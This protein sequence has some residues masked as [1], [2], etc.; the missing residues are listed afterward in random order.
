MPPLQIDG[1][2]GEG[3]GQVLRTALALSMITGQAVEITQVRAGRK[4]PGLAPQHLAGILAAQQITQAEVRGA[5]VGSMTVSFSP[6]QPAQPDEYHFDISKLS[7]RGSAGSVTLLFQ[8]ILLPLALAGG[9]SRVTVNGGTHVSM[10][11]PAYYFEKV[12]LPAL[13]GIGIEARCE[14]ESPGWYPQGGGQLVVSIEGSAKLKGI[15]LS[16]RGEFV[17][18]E[19]LAVASNLP[20]DI[21]QRIASRANNVCKEAGL[22]PGIQARRSSGVSTGVGIVMTIQYANVVAGFSALG[23]R[24]KP[25][26]LVADEAALPLVA[27]HR[28]EMALEPHLPDQILPALALADGPSVLTTQEITLHTLT[29]IAVVRHFIDRE[30]SVEGTEKSPGTI[31][32]S[33]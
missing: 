33:G 10:S 12:L 31:R 23:E 3:G 32:V 25:S 6:S 30:I 14:M 17:R 11:P 7:G 20:S 16:S 13:H 27:F 18:V 21:P 19:G 9:Q 2:Q 15:D 1:S 24:G 22:N 4:K 26:D 5:A 29:N 8:T 28:Q